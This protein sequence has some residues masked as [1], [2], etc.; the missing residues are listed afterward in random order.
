MDA[1]AR[2]VWETVSLMEYVI[3]IIV[4]AVLALGTGGWLLF[5][6]PR[7]PRCP[8]RHQAKRLPKRPPPSKQRRRPGSPRLPPG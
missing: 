5:Q 4:I 3:L 7:R 1:A 2:G 6:R 8:Q